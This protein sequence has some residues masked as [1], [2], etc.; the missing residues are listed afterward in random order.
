M[1]W[2]N[3][4]VDAALREESDTILPSSG[5]AD[6]VMAEV[7]REVSVLPP[8]PFPW[9]RALPGFAGSALVFI[10]FLA[11]AILGWTQIQTQLNS[12]SVWQA[13]ALSVADFIER[14]ATLWTVGS[15]FLAFCSLTLIRRLY[16][17]R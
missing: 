8:I 6:A 14:P 17:I 4:R 1:K 3:E 11:T 16:S 2:T 13:L 9:K 7:R 15:T 5:F 12:L 10:V